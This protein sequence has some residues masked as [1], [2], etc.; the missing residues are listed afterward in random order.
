MKKQIA[1]F[2]SFLAIPLLLLVLW[3]G[4]AAASGRV[5]LDFHTNLGFLAGIVAIVAEI[6]WG[7]GLNLLATLLLV[8]VVGSG[9]YRSV[10]DNPGSF[11]QTIAVIGALVAILANSNNLY[12][13]FHPRPSRR[14]AH[15]K[16]AKNLHSS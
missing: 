1:T 9:L 15:R 12:R 5:S 14:A 13:S 3:A 7:G 4:W 8:L 6:L 11:H 16:T 10:Q 2:L